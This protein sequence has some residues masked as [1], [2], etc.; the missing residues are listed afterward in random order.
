MY[1]K[2]VQRCKDSKKFQKCVD[3]EAIKEIGTFNYIEK[4]MSDKNFANLGNSI[5]ELIKINFIDVNKRNIIILTDK[6]FDYINDN[7]IYR[8]I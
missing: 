6:F 4:Y 8:R 3:R 5:I 2:R 1:L 7:Y